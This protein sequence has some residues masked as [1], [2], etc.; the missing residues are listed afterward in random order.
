[1]ISTRQFITKK[2]VRS[3]GSHLKPMTMIPKPISSATVHFIQAGICSTSILK[4][5]RDTQG[6]P[7]FTLANRLPWPISDERG[8]RFRVQARPTHQR[9]IQLLLRHQTLNVVRLDAAAIENP[10]SGGLAGGTLR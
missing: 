6:R 2:I 4:F 8:E 9:T 5:Y 1:M 7:A 10:Q 3:T